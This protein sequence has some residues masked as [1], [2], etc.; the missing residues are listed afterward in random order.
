MMTLICTAFVSTVIASIGAVTSIDGMTSIDASSPLV[1]WA[2]RTVVTDSG[3]TFDWLGVTARVQVTRATH[4]SATIMSTARRGTRLKAYASDQGFM[5][6]PQVQFWVGEQLASPHTLWLSNRPGDTIVTL[7]NIVAPQYATGTTTVVSF[8]TDGNFTA[9]A[10][11]DQLGGAD[12]RRIE[13]IG[14][15]ITAATN[16]V[17]PEGATHSCGDVGYQSDWSAT[18]EALLCHRFGASCSSIAVG[19][20]CVMR[21]CGGLQMPASPPGTITYSRP[22]THA[23]CMRQVLVAYLAFS[24]LPKMAGEKG[25]TWNSLWMVT[26][27]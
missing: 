17:R 26:S 14:D 16:V 23:S 24:L 3:V 13:F 21:E 12:K 15:S 19:G 7:E 11:E 25:Q 18:Y 27:R 4:V 2:G 9:L 1:D 5:M 6:Y 10:P 22:Q 8:S 20:K